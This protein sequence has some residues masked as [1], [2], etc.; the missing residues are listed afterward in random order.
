MRDI[1]CVMVQYNG[2]GALQREYI[3]A[4]PKHLGKVKIKRTW[5]SLEPFQAQY[6]VTFPI[7]SEIV[8]VTSYEDKERAAY[9]IGLM[10]NGKYNSICEAESFQSE[11]RNV[12]EFWAPFDAELESL[13][14]K[15]FQLV[16]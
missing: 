16:A 5:Q 13:K 6:E 10:Q 2:I 15:R 9:S 14:K 1:C 4:R 8:W 11:I 7:S 3:L 12:E